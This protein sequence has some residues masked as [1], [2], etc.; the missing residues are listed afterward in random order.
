MVVTF[1]DDEL[2][3]G[4]EPYGPMGASAPSRG[5]AGPHRS[6]ALVGDLEAG[7]GHL[8]SA[9]SGIELV[10]VFTFH[11]RADEEP[12]PP[13]APPPLLPLRMNAFPSVSAQ[14]LTA[15]ARGMPPR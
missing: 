6:L 15:S 4:V 8:G 5:Q 13:W 1:I 14:S 3:S 12:P 11:A 2:S 7:L 9:S 10:E